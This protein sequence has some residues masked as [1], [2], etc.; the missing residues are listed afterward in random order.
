MS[1]ILPDDFQMTELGPLPKEWR[2]VAGG[3]VGG[4]DDSGCTEQPACF[5]TGRQDIHFV[6]REPLCSW[7]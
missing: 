2:V 7:Y 1:D 5:Y 6:V 3:E 4:G